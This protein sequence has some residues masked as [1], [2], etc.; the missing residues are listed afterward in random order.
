MSTW[1]K[2]GSSEKAQ[3]SQT[4]RILVSVLQYLAEDA[5]SSVDSADR[6]VKI[7]SN[8][9]KSTFTPSSNHNI[10]EQVQSLL[11]QLGWKNSQITLKSADLLEMILGSNRYLDQSEVNET[12]LN[13][14]VKMISVAIGQKIMTREVDALVNFDHNNKTYRVN[15]QAVEDFKPDMKAEV[16]TSATSIGMEEKKVEAKVETVVISSINTGN[17]D[18]S[19]I[20]LPVFSNKLPNLKML[21]LLKDVCEEFSQSWYSQ[22]P[23]LTGSD[24]KSNLAI[25]FNFLITK[26]DESGNDVLSIGAQIGSYYADAIKATWPDEKHINDEILDAS[27]G[28]IIRDIKAR[29]LCALTPAQSCG[30]KIGGPNRKFCDLSMAVWQG[31]LSKLH[32][33]EYTFSGYY[34]AGKRDSVCLMEFSVK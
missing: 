2:R 22:V 27:G 13:L 1:T 5:T 17:F 31:A 10:N 16:K 7:A 33:K 32:T 11:L 3:Q 12:G 26:A 19:Q 23:E 30:S 20:I 29:S 6:F 34:A 28:S 14:L 15:I 9:L 21:S 8:V 4:I 25:L 18:T 24:D